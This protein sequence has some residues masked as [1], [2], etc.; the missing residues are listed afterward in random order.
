ME[1]VNIG[2]VYEIG[3]V[4][5]NVFKKDYKVIVKELSIFEDYIK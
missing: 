5:K 2:I 3:I 1:L 4:L